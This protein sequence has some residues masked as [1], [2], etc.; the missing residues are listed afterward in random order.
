MDNQHRHHGDASTP[1]RRLPQSH[2]IRTLRSRTTVTA[3]MSSRRPPQDDYGLKGQSEPGSDNW[4]SLD[5]W[6]SQD[7]WEAH[8]NWDSPGKSM[9]HGNRE[10]HGNGV[11]R[12]ASNGMSREAYHEVS[13][14]GAHEV[15]HGGAH[16]SSR[17]ASRGGAHDSSRGASRG[18][19]RGASRGAWEEAGARVRDALLEK[20]AH[21]ERDAHLERAARLEAAASQEEQELLQAEREFQV[22]QEQ[23]Q[24]FW[25][26]QGAPA[27]AQPHIP[28]A[29][30]KRRGWKFYTLLTLCMLLLASGGIAFKIYQ[31]IISIDS[32]VVSARQN[33]Y[34]LKEGATLQSVVR[35]LAGNSY[36]R[37][38]LS[39]WVKL[40]HF[41]Y[42]VIQKGS[43]LIDGRKTLPEILADMRQGNILKI[44]LPSV[45]LVEGMTISMVTRRLKAKDDLTQVPELDLV[46]ADPAFFINEILLPKGIQDQ[47][48]L[49]AVGGTHDSL[50]G[51]LLPATYEYQPGTSSTIEVVAAALRKMADYMRE[52]YIERD[53]SIDGIISSPYEVLILA[54]LV[55]RESSLPEE[56]PT[57]AGVFLNRLKQNMRLQTDPAVMYGVSPDF[58]G[59]LR[60]S[61]LKKD[62]PYNTYTRQGLP[63]TPIAMPS[64]E[65]IQ[66]VL[67]PALTTALYFVAKGPDPQDGH[68]FSSSL[69]EHN[70]AVKE[71]RQAVRDYKAQQKQ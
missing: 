59:P 11:A 31:D 60:L 15:S 3:A 39:L 18:G 17:V 54:S 29:P 58:R 68:I 56:R 14:G 63:P 38:E 7:N 47:T 37:Q 8:E 28:P 51:L 52:E 24:E 33:P 62:T 26:A 70:R 20:A 41:E 16:G 43:Y 1:V 57:I 48:L 21:L 12:E 32:Y 25:Q 30:K 5:N 22:Q 67:H 64:E 2:D 23:E 53:Q 69:N 71:Y 50:E 61:Q 4:E 27:S 10:R 35:D 6:D 55:E 45:P 40:H 65:S 13:H 9:P 42:P 36:P 34:E 44:K 49:Q 46:I 66:A 19:A